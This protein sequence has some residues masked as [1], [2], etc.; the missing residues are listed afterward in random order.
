[1]DD[2]NRVL[3][4]IVA[5]IFVIA[6]LVV[7]QNC[8]SHDE[9]DD[10]TVGVMWRTN[11]SSESYVYTCRAIEAAGGSVVKVG[12]IFFD[13]LEYDGNGKLVSGINEIGYLDQ[14][15][16]DKVKGADWHRS[17]IEEALAGVDF[18]VFPGGDDISP[19]LYKIPQ[20]WVDSGEDRAFDP[21]RDVSDYLAMKYCLEKDIP[22]VGICRGM[23]FLSVVSGAEMA[24][25]IPAFFR[26]HSS[27]DR[28]TH[29]NPM[30]SQGGYRDYSSH[31]VVLEAG[32]CIHGIMGKELLT[33]CPSWHHQAVLNVDGTSLKVT[34][35]TETDGIRIIESVERTD[36]TCAFGV[37][38]HPEA[39]VCKILD[40]LPNKDD[41]M[42]YEDAMR[43]FEWIVDY[44]RS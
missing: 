13:D 6:G 34:G 2:R 24:Q 36:K 17:N 7:A 3:T 31:D 30:P 15:T 21:E 43:L 12:Q 18:V 22:L 33:G 10:W 44:R 37:Q 11:Q 35:Y 29:R 38:Y 1:M 9:D 42:S 16:A 5:A 40:D 8:Y 23:Q 39:A 26:E 41:Y 25:D 20:E 28:D 19:S 4:V 32:S 14:E 27:D